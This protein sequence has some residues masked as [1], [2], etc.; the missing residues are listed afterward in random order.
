MISYAVNRFNAQPV[1]GASQPLF[2]ACGAEPDWVRHRGLDCV[3]AD[4]FADGVALARVSP[5][6][7]AVL[8]RSD[9]T[10]TRSVLAEVEAATTDPRLASVRWVLLASNGIDIHGHEH[11]RGSYTD[12]APGGARRTPRALAATNPA[13]AVVSVGSLL[14][15]GDVSLET[16]GDLLTAGWDAG[17]G[18]YGVP[19]LHFSY[20]GAFED[21]PHRQQG[22]PVVPEGGW[23]STLAVA[24][25]EPTITFG[26][27]TALTRPA[28]LDRAI[29]SIAAVGGDGARVFLTGTLPADRLER[30]VERLRT[31]YPGLQWQW[32]PL[33]PGSQPSRSA[34]IEMVIAGADTD[35]VWFLDDDDY[36]EPGATDRVITAIHTSGRPIVVGRSARIRE[37]WKDDRLTASR[38]EAPFDSSVWFNAFTGWNSLPV[39]SIVYPRAAVHSRLV[40]RSLDHDLGEDYALFLLAL[41]D[42]GQDVV[43][44]EETIANVSLR[45][46]GD[47]VVTAT[48]R[49]EWLLNIASFLSDLTR[50]GTAGAPMPWLLGE[51]IAQSVPREMVVE[52]QAAA[53]DAGMQAAQRPEWWKTAFWRAVPDRAHPAVRRALRRLRSG[54]GRR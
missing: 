38:R 41:T 7:L 45:P 6:S 49:E 33:S 50:N 51:A 14:E 36:L 44:V 42:P 17:Y 32:Q 47:N 10:P 4:D 34:G 43:V 54:D 9:I 25:P 3:S 28:M 23:R 16:P 48:D 26:V 40:D 11:D 21:R 29:E 8:I 1:T 52:L 5:A 13:V 2:I 19:F 15:L 35:Y 24:R 53:R 31:S 22:N 18:S 20:N 27:R 37:E 30:E 12:R 46:G 39:C